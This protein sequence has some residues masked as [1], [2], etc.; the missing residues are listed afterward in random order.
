MAKKT[1]AEKLT[2]AI[3]KILEE[4]E[5]DVRSDVIEATEA[6]TKAGAKAVKA[7]A[8]D[9]FDGTGKYAAGW[10]QRTY[11]GRTGAEGT[12]YNARLPGLAHLLEHGHA[13]RG[14]G[15]TQPREHIKPVEEQIIKEFEEKITE[16]VQ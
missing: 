9:T 15:R 5:E 14:G 13:K 11:K 6:V 12:I 4:Y 2:D 16:A 3:G 1:P 10:T 8:K 7:A